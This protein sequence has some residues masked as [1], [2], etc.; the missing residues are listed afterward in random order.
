MN[1]CKVYMYDSILKYSQEALLQGYI[2]NEIFA[3]EEHM[4]DIFKKLRPYL[5]ALIEGAHFEGRDYFS[6]L[7]SEDGKMY[8]KMYAQAK[9]NP[10]NDKDKLDAID[11]HLKPLSRRLMAK[12]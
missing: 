4:E 3:I 1:L 6:I 7:V 5:A 11:T 9:A 2:G 10:L 12:M 8:D